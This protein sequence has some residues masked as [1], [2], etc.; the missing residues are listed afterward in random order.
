MHLL[1]RISCFCLLLST[2]LSGTAQEGIHFI[3]GLSWQQIREKA[4][5]ER[6]YILVDCHATWCGPCR[7]MEQDI[8]PLPEVGA[9]FNAHFINVKVQ[10]D[11][12]ARD[13]EEVKAWYADSR[14]IAEQYKVRVLP[15]FLFFGPDGELVHQQP[16]ATNRAAD[17]LQLG[18]QALDSNQQA[19]TLL[20]KA[21]AQQLTADQ[22]RETAIYFL[23]LQEPAPAIELSNSYMAGLSRP[24]D[25]AAI[26]FIAP[27]VQ[28]SASMGFRLY[29]ED[30]AAVNAV[31]GPNVAQEKLRHILWKEYFQEPARADE[32]PDWKAIHK[33]ASARY[34]ALA[35]MISKM[36]AEG[37]VN[38]YLSRQDTA[39]YLKAVVHYV[40]RYKKELSVWERNGAAIN[41]AQRTSHLGLL[42]KALGWMEPCDPTDASQLQTRA[43][44]LY[45]LGRRTE[46]MSLLNKALAQAASYQRADL[47]KLYQKMEQQQPL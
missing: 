38:Y 27:F 40:S 45:Q 6:K 15:T 14:Q 43:Q 12:T 24:F 41:L 17:F 25:A 44:L 36:A 9:F 4:R 42:K 3:H 30:T 39:R 23:N 32:A 7:Q 18:R 47:E 31:L 46:A 29:Q 35:G 11:K 1:Y 20:R 34:P 26:R 13:N 8:F 5:T 19:Y 37:E 33:Q 22:L 2:S 16:G 21:A 28:S 10:L